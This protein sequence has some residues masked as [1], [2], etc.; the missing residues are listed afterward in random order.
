[1]ERFT[2]KPPKDNESRLV[3][4]NRLVFRQTSKETI[5]SLAQEGPRQGKDVAGCPRLANKPRTSFLVVNQ[6]MNII[7]V[8]GEEKRGK[9]SRLICLYD[10][11]IVRNSIG[12]DPLVYIERGGLI[13]VKN[14]SKI[15]SP[16]FP[17]QK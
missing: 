16:S 4:K 13:L 12:H 7:E 1:M 2:S 17:R 9:R 15:R 8:E 5:E 14:I 6:G 10:D 11:W 3:T